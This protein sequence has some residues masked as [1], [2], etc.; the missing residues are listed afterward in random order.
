LNP[1]LIYALN[2]GYGPVGPDK[3]TGGFDLAAQARS[4][5]MNLPREEG[6]PPREAAFGIVDQTAG[7]LMA[8]GVVLALFVRD[9]TGVGQRVDTSLLG[10]ALSMQAMFLQAHLLSGQ[11]PRKPQRERARSPVWNTYRCQD[12]RWI[13]LAMAYMITEWPIF[14]RA[15]GNEELTEDPRFNTHQA[16]LENNESL[17]EILD[18]VFAAR[19]AEEWARQLQAEG[20]ICQLICDYADVASDP[21]VLANE[22]IID[23]E[24]PRVGWIQEVGLPIQLCRTPGRVRPGYPLHGQHTEEV[25]LEVGRYTWDEI[26]S[27]K[28]AGAII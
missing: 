10:T 17:I 26:E 6:Q 24:H 7:M 19:P 14:C 25:L 12:D 4:G 8:F 23:V 9:R 27:L 2:S 16:R 11:L 3:D 21:Q 1:E 28:K 15:I 20:M 5:L 13:I 18:K 22:Y